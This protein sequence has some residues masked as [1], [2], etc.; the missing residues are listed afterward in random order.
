[1]SNTDSY[2]SFIEGRICTPEGSDIATIL[3]YSEEELEADH[4]FIQWLFPLPEPS[5]YNPY[6]PVIDIDELQQAL[7]QHPMLQSTMLTALK[8][9]QVFWGIS[10]LDRRRIKKL[11]GHNGLRFSRV[12]QSLVYHGLKDEA[13]NMLKV[14]LEE[15][16]SEKSVLSPTLDYKTKKSLW[17]IGFIRACELTRAYY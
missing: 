17:E 9:M 4:A 8:K 5:A 12:L 7:S 1:M 16:G 15:V 10:P 3:K 11:N 14:V 13:E 6:A 2:I